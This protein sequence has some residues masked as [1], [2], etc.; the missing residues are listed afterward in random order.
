M[1]SQILKIASENEGF[2]YTILCEIKGGHFNKLLPPSPC[3]ELLERNRTIWGPGSLTK[4]QRNGSKSV[5]RNTVLN[6]LIFS[7]IIC[8]I[9]GMVVL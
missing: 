6:S 7:F 1:L 2:F 3:F 9:G 8:E 4:Y 5:L